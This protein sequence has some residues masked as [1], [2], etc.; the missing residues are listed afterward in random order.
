[1]LYLQTKGSLCK[2][3]LKNIKKLVTVSAISMLMTDK[4]TEGKLEEL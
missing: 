2:Q 1:M 3:V 4:K